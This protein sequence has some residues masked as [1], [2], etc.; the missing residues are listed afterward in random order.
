MSSKEAFNA[1]RQIEDQL[2]KD[3]IQTVKRNSPAVQTLLKVAAAST[4]NTG[5]FMR[6][7]QIM[8]TNS[9]TANRDVSMLLG[10][11]GGDR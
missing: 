6:Q 4:I 10:K 1:E 8:L 5:L 2:F 11:K 3:T 7:D 9:Y